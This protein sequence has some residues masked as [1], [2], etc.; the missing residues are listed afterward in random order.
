MHRD[1]SVDRAEKRSQV[2]QEKAR[3]DQKPLL[4]EPDETVAN[5]RKQEPVNYPVI[6]LPADVK[7]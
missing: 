5:K 2:Q 1:P 7:T 3:D 4:D 6:A